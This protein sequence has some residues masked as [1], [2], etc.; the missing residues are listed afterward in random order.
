MNREL[1]NPKVLWAWSMYDWANSVYSLTITTAIFPIYY[2]SVTKAYAIK[3][4]LFVDGNP[5]IRF[6]GFEIINTA[7]YAYALSI[8]F[9]IVAIVSPIL[10][11]M[12][13]FGGKKKTYMKRFVLLGSLSCISMYFFDVQN[14]S[15][16]LVAFALATVGYAGSIVFYNAFLPLIATEDKFDALSAK[17]YSFGYLGSVI[18]LIINLLLIQ[19]ADWFFPIEKKAAT[20]FATQSYQSFEM[21]AAQALTYYQQFATKLAFVSVG[22]WWFGFSLITFYYLPKEDTITNARVNKWMNGFAQIAIVWQDLKQNIKLKSYLIS[23]FL[24]SMGLQTVMYVASLFGA[25]ELNM[26]A[27]EL[28]L[29]VLL[30][31]LV[32]I[33]G[34]YLFAKL[35]EKKGNIWVLSLGTIIWVFICLLAYFV[36]TNVQFFALASLVGFVMGGLQA[37]LRATFSKLMPDETQQTASYFAFYDLTEKLAIVFGTFVYGY[38][39]VVTGSMRVSTLVLGSFFLMGLWILRRIPNFKIHVG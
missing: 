14:V 6:L 32:A 21:A 15:I 29:T 3:H 20:L 28:I 19:K 7:A 36:Q 4:N 1:N 10:S 18:L 5:A 24:I 25:K 39:E 11:G 30:I 34:A 27:T 12:A 8:A 33:L 9:L 23:F 35:S 2:E 31:Q 26:Q 16:G 38:L 37:L 13:D 17:G 22:L